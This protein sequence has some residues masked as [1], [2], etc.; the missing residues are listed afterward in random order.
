MIF[1][2]MGSRNQN[3]MDITQINL[4][5]SVPPIKTEHSVGAMFYYPHAL[6]MATMV[7]T[8]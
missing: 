4:S 2:E 5:Q 7:F 1:R 3:I 8:V 6:M